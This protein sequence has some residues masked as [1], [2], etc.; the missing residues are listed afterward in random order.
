MFA[1]ISKL[2]RNEIIRRNENRRV[3]FAKKL[4]FFRLKTNNI[5]RQAIN[6]FRVFIISTI[7]KIA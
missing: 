2:L 6:L 5:T 4:S 1:N 7:W 3:K